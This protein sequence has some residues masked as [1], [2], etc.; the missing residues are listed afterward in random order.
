MDMRY[1]NIR[2][3]ITC[4]IRYIS[5][6]MTGWILIFSRSYRSEISFR[7]TDARSSDCF[8]ICV[9]SSRIHP[10]HMNAIEGT[11][12]GG[13][14][15]HLSPCELGLKLF[16]LGRRVHHANFR[17][18]I[19]ADIASRIERRRV[20][21]GF[22]VFIENDRVSFRQA[23]VSTNIAC[24]QANP[25]FESPSVQGSFALLQIDRGQRRY[26]ALENSRWFPGNSCCGTSLAGTNAA[27]TEA[28]PR[29]TVTIGCLK[30]LP[31]DRSNTP[32]RMSNIDRLP[33]LFPSPLRMKR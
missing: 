1:F 23:D 27:T 28:M 32:W 18:S 25:V 12:G 30:A 8:E 13:C 24:R 6:I 10:I 3:E 22:E 4:S 7:S 11:S 31:R 14:G 33:A 16:R 17:T 19:L 15:H 9:I 29:P 2:H 5:R 21:R 26:T 20:F